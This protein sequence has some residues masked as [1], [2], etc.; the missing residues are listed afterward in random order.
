MPL[1]LARVNQIRAIL[2]QA[3]DLDAAE[4]ILDETC[5]PVGCVLLEY[6]GPLCI[7]VELPARCAGRRDEPTTE[8]ARRLHFDLLLDDN[9]TAR[10]TAEAIADLAFPVLTEGYQ[11]WYNGPEAERS[12]EEICM[13]EDLFD[14]ALAADVEDFEAIVEDQEA[15]EARLREADPQFGDVA[16]QAGTSLRLIRQVAADLDILDE[17]TP[18]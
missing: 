9:D 3:E 5:N 1:Y 4:M 10:E 12:D 14:R 13:P 17:E 6:R 15:E 8:D 2:I 16:L 11:D 18:P 7:D